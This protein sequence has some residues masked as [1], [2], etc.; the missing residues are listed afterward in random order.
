MGSSKKAVLRESSKVTGGPKQGFARTH[1]GGFWGYS[2]S[3]TESSLAESGSFSARSHTS[4]D[5]RSSHRRFPRSKTTLNVRHDELDRIKGYARKENGGYWRDREHQDPGVRPATARPADANTWT[6]RGEK[7]WTPRSAYFRKKLGEFYRPE[8]H[9]VTR[10]G[11]S[12]GGSEMYPD[13]TVPALDIFDDKAADPQKPKPGY[14]RTYWG[15]YYRDPDKGIDE[16]ARRTFQSSV[17]PK[18]GFSRT[19]MGGFFRGKTYEQPGPQEPLAHEEF[20]LP[21]NQDKKADPSAPGPGYTRTNYG[22]YYMKEK[23]F[24]M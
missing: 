14:T 15:S 12:L 22:G 10:K 21:A 1:D 18:S 24:C 23:Q 6:P 13:T 9:D 11:A 8:P 3:A 19:P 17:P 20:A 2:R 16:S 5:L 4:S 7:T